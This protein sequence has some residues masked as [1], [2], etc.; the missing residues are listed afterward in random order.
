M[1]RKIGEVFDYEGKRLI[2]EESK[3]GCDDCF[4]DGQ[5]NCE[6][7]KEISGYCGISNRSDRKGV[8]FVEVKN[9][10][11]QEQIEQPQEL[12]IC[13]SL[14]LC[15]E[16]MDLWS[17]L[18]GKVKLFSKNECFVTVIAEDESTWDINADGTMAYGDRI[19]IEPMLY[20]SREQRDWTK[21]RYKL[22][23]N[24]MPRTWYDFLEMIG[25]KDKEEDW[26]HN[27]SRLAIR[28]LL[29]PTTDDFLK[30]TD[31]HM[32]MIKLHVLRDFYRQ[33]WKPEPNAQ[34][35]NE[36]IISN[37]MDEHD[38]LVP[39]REERDRLPTVSRFL[40]FQDEATAT[41]FCKNF[42]GLIRIAGD[43]I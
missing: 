7:K 8:I 40:T 2:V 17:P 34:D 27:E 26:E 4:F 43:L 38:V 6:C 41:E 9:E 35:T 13:Q 22:P 21:F 31:R 15:P 25:V 30:I 16:G 33:G 20:P 29:K 36:W 5:R 10:Q 12:N 3:S 42:D 39:F 18:L 1:E 37:I 32:A 11:P 24:R 28:S 19:S 23:L 14:K